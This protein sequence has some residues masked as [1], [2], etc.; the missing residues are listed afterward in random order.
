MRHPAA[1]PDTDPVPGEVPVLMYHSIGTGAGR[2]F[3]RFVVDPGEFAAQMGYLDTEGYCPVTAADLACCRSSGRPLPPRPVVLTFDDAYTDFYSAALPVLREHDFRA[4]LFV[5]TAYVGSY[6]RWD[7]SLREENRKILSW[8]ALR[9]IAVEGVEVAAHSHTHP[10]LD[11]LA[12]AVVLD[13]VSRSRRLTE[14]NLAVQV[15]GFAYPFGYWDRAARTAVAAAGFS[16]ACAVGDLATTPGDDV[17]TLPRLTVN[18]GIG[19]TGL[20]R[21]LQARPTTGAR[22]TA[23]AKRLTWRAIRRTVPAVGGDPREGGQPT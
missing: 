19:V 5:P 14:D 6:A 10:Q 1:G 16:Y 2:G 23:T 11:R 12:A 4:T 7:R 22:R 20:A 3:R 8:P 13:E 17:L 9:D 18:A 15:Q 21:L